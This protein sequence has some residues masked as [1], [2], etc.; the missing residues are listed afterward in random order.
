MST[1]MGSSQTFD[2]KITA[3]DI[4]D[5]IKPTSWWLL[6]NDIADAHAHGQSDREARL[7]KKQAK[8]EVELQSKAQQMRREGKL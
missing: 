2:N 3:S 6:Q 1:T 8:M 4:P 5:S 7:L